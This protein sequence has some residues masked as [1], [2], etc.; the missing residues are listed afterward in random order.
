MLSEPNG[1]TT[2]RLPRRFSDLSIS[3]TFL[4]STMHRVQYGRFEHL[5]IENTEPIFSPP[6]R[7]IQVK[8]IGSCEPV[9][10]VPDDWILKEP[11][12]DL[13]RE[14]AALGNGT[15]E[16]LEFRRG[17]PCL[18]EFAVPSGHESGRK[19]AGHA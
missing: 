12:L 19:G 7:L 18:L 17:L 1:V 9:I 13:L 6:P 11:I 10:A 5:R 2:N 8:R 16:R 14:F 3:A 4:I 15:I